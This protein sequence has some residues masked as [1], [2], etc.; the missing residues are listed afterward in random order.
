MRER[1]CVVGGSYKGRGRG[2][3][4]RQ[5]GL[6]HLRVKPDK[7]SSLRV[8]LPSQS[9]TPCLLALIF[10]FDMENSLHNLHNCTY[11]SIILHLR[12]CERGEIEDY[13]LSNNNN[14]DKSS[15]MRE[16]FLSI[17]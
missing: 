16:M 7:A 9:T 6:N 8:A 1:G 11:T 17:N 3:I 2:L 14:N 12:P 5:L 15:I 13:Y 4:L 10:W